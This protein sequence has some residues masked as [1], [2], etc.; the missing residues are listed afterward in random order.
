[1]TDNSVSSPVD[2]DGTVQWFNSEKG[3]GFLKPAAGGEDVFVH[4][5]N[6]EVQGFAALT[7]GQQVTYQLGEG[8][9]GPTATNV[10]PV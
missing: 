6:I 3:Y 7:E 10:R 8:P 1:M 2:L 4:Y 5:S 9:K